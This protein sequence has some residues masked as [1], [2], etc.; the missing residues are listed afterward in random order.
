MFRENTSI[1][2]EIWVRALIRTKALIMANT[3]Y[4]IYTSTPISSTDKLPA[5]YYIL[6]NCSFWM[7]QRFANLPK[8]ISALEILALVKKYMARKISKFCK[9]I[10]SG[11][12]LCN[13]YICFQYSELLKK[14]WILIS[15]WDTHQILGAVKYILAMFGQSEKVL[16][17]SSGPCHC[18]IF[19]EWSNWH[20]TFFGQTSTSLVLSIS[21]CFTK[22]ATWL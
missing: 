14:K 2:W 19:S 10:F 8:D 22:R 11:E 7:S 13:S 9:G 17:L 1:I 20:A 12:L 15:P 21:G 4:E 6:K 18:K 5:E 16:V 3:A